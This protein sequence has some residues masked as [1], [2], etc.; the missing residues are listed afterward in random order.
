MARCAV[1][2]LTDGL[3]VNVVMA[4]PT[5]LA[6]DACQLVE[7]LDGVMCDIGWTYDGVTFIAPTPPE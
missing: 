2:Q 1:C 7:I 5:D 4:D 3:V 6:P